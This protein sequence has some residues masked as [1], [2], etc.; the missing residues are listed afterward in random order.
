MNASYKRG[1]S[2][3][4]MIIYI[5]IAA[6]MMIF[7]VQIV[8]SITKGYTDIRLTRDIENSAMISLDR[9][10]RDIRSAT[11]IDTAQSQFGV[12]PGRLVLQKTEG[13]V[14]TV[15]DFYVSNGEVQ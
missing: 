7:V 14:T 2:L 4:E 1:F 15:T 5:T 13:G 8:I 10:T 12:S 9:M 6:V 3:F 11:A